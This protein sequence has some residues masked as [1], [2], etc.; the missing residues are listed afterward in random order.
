MALVLLALPAGL[1]A[2]QS[3]TAPPS[4]PGGGQVLV[5][6]FNE[7]QQKVEPVLTRQGCD[8]TGDCHGGGIRGTFQL[9]P[10]GAK[11]VRFDFDQSSLQTTITPRDSSAILRMPLALVAGGSPHPYKPFADTSDS[12]YVA[13]RKWVQDGVVQ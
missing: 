11:N 13:M 9:S 3:P 1:Y 4:P 10:P 8:A 12:D 7:L 6:D 5:L 2:C